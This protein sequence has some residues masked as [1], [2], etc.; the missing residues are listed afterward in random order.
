MSP[1]GTAGGAGAGGAGVA[2][3]VGVL[4]VG[5]PSPPQAETRNPAPTNKV[6]SRAR[7]WAETNLPGSEVILIPSW[8][9]FR[10]R[11]TSIVSAFVSTKSSRLLQAVLPR[12]CGHFKFGLRRAK[13]RL[14]CR[15]RVFSDTSATRTGSRSSAAAPTSS[16]GTW[17]N[18]GP[19]L[20]RPGNAGIHTGTAPRSGANRA[21]LRETKRGDGSE[22][23]ALPVKM[24]LRR[25]PD[26]ADG[27]Q[28]RERRP[29]VGTAAR[30]AA[31]AQTPTVGMAPFSART[32]HGAGWRA[33]AGPHRE[34]WPPASGR[35]R[36]GARNLRR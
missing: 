16:C 18:N 11:V 1:F 30:R 2:P 10:T 13:F 6:G 28:A 4:V 21:S 3:G 22:R 20:H 17:A 9:R 5:V 29:P 15:V 7:R 34:N 23:R 8:A 26:R 33:T 25:A 14:R 12:L 19:R 35:H 32:P 27:A 24:Q 31:A 36:A